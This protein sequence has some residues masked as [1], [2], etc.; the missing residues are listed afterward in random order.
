ME[1]CN[2]VCRRTHAVLRDRRISLFVWI[3]RFSWVVTAIALLMV[4]RLSRVSI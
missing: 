1:L 4:Y 3:L 2:F